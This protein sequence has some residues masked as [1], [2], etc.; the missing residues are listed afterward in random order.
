MEI[1]NSFN[2][3]IASIKED[4]SIFARPSFTHHDDKSYTLS[5]IV[6][7]S[8]DDEGYAYP[9]ERLT[10]PEEKLLCLRLCD[11]LGVTAVF[12]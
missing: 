1:T 8:I 2:N 3:S 5:G 12:A 11:E 9:A 6:A 4:G 7:V 10:T